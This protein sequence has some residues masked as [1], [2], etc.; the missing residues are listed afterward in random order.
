MTIFRNTSSNVTTPPL[1]IATKT[2]ASDVQ[3]FRKLTSSASAATYAVGVASYNI[4]LTVAEPCW[5][6]EHSPA[7][8][9]K[10]QFARTVDPKG[11]PVSIAVT[12]SS[13]LEFGA[14]ANS[15]VIRSSGKV[16]GKVAAPRP[17]VTYTFEPK[18]SS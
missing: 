4:V 1:H 11:G 18:T 7:S 2:T 5:V 13:T 3:P 14:S 8:T 15:L 12:G 9:P 10:P 16:I 17:G 6:Q